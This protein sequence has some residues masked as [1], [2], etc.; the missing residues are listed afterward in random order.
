MNG[1]CTFGGLA[2]DTTY[3]IVTTG[4]TLQRYVRGNEIWVAQ[5]PETLIKT[6]FLPIKPKAPNVGFNDDTN[7]LVYASLT[8][9]EI[10]NLEYSLDG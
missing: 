10:A 3:K 8:P 4:Q 6:P 5:S 1:R 9:A 7:T 2:S